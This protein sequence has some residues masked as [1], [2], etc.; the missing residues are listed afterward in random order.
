MRALVLSARPRPCRRGRGCLRGA[1]LA[2]RALDRVLPPHRVS[3]RGVGGA[4][5]GARRGRRNGLFR[6]GAH[7]AALCAL[8]GRWRSRC[9]LNGPGEP[10]L[11]ARP[12]RGLGRWAGERCRA[13]LAAAVLACAGLERARVGHAGATHTLQG[14]SRHAVPAGHVRGVAFRH[15]PHRQGHGRGAR[16]APVRSA[17][18]YAAA[19]PRPRRG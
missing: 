13:L 11:A 6:P 9:G 8:R 4:R 3:R 1:Q 16:R 10:G 15:E 7:C 14:G 12:G 19:G 2:T 17:A 5:S 18:C